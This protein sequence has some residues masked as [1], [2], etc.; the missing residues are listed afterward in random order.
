M[1]PEQQTKAN[2]LR[3]AM[4]KNFNFFGM[5][6]S[7]LVVVRHEDDEGKDVFT[8]VHAGEG[9]N[10]ANWH[11]SYSPAR[12]YRAVMSSKNVSLFAVES[13]GVTYDSRYGMTEKAY[14]ALFE[15]N[16][17]DL[18]VGLDS[19]FL[20]GKSRDALDGR[21]WTILTGEDLEVDNFF[22]Y[23]QGRHIVHSQILEGQYPEDY[24]HLDV[25]FRPAIVIE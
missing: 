12:S 1:S 25:R 18:I 3:T 8:L 23:A 17:H 4:A 13:D 14:L 22:S 5:S 16:T 19:Q 10:I 15:E 24:S 21:T 9:I 20:D 2:H 11:R 6:E 7:D